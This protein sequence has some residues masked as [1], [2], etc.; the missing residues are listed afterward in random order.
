M[1]RARN[2]HEKKVQQITSDSD[3]E[4][5][6]LRAECEKRIEEIKADNVISTQQLED[7]VERLEAIAEKLET[8]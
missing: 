5:Q 6:Q 7:D 1:Q 8:I 4:V 3:A 2:E